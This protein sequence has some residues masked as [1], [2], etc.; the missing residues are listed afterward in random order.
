MSYS[1]ILDPA[2][3]DSALA[4]CRGDYQANL[5]RGTESL[6]GSTL[7]GAAKR[8]GGRYLASRRAILL[9]M[10][11]AGIVWCERKGDHGKRILV[12]GASK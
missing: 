7:K 5:I 2:A 1:M 4:L 10:T 9:R 12:I 6:S 8:W 11:E 3:L